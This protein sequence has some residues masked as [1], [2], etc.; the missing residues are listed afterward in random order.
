MIQQALFLFN[1]VQPGRPIEVTTLRSSGYVQYMQGPLETEQQ[2]FSFDDE[3]GE[4][5]ILIDE[6]TSDGYY[7]ELTKTRL[8]FFSPCVQKT[9]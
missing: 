4:M 7:F 6:L 9:S 8:P 1:T 5:Q 2:E 3:T